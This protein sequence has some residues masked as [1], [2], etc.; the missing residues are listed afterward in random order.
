M[1]TNYKITCIRC[2]GT[3]IFDIDEE[4]SECRICGSKYNFRSLCSMEKFT[5][6]AFP[7][8]I[9]STQQSISKWDRRF[10]DL[11]KHIAEWSKDPS[12]KCGAVITKGNK[13][14]S[15]GF[16]G[17]ASGIEDFAERLANREVK[18][19]M[20]IHAEEN[21]IIFA[22]QDLEGCTI[23]LWPFPPC[24]NC[25]AKI[26]QTGITRVVAPIASSDLIERWGDS[27]KISANMYD[28]VGVEFV[29]V[30]DER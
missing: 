15:L 30:A 7:I 8:L 26:I 5:V 12:T 6:K 17:L 14:I 2:E 4:K 25:A 22:K 11:A 29:E 23:Y 20:V 3:S 9:K 19:K 16:N 27:L 18:Y 21:A 24:S 10:L 1:A 13:I 28:E